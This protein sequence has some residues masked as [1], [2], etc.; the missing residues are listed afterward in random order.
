MVHYL[1]IGTPLEQA[2]RYANA[3]GALTVTK[4]GAIPSLPTKEQL[5]AFLQSREA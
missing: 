5:A 3:V 1:S 4:K 2:V